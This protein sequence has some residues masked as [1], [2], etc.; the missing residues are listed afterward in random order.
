MRVG[1]GG[2]RHGVVPRSDSLKLAGRF[3]DPLVLEHSGGHV[4]RENRAVAEPIARFLTRYAS[5]ARTEPAC[6][7]TGQ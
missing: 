7:G 3:A 5:T 1:G 2:P 4:I 6:E